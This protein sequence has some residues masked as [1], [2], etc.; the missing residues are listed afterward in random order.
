M[1]SRSRNCACC[2]SYGVRAHA[3]AT[4]TLRDAGHATWDEAESGVA[5]ATRLLSWMLEP[6]GPTRDA[7]DAAERLLDQHGSLSGVLAALRFGRD[8]VADVS[9][10]AR[11]NLTRFAESLQ[12][13]LHEEI[14]ETVKLGSVAKIVEYVR[15]ELRH[16]RV[17]MLRILFLDKKNGLIAD[18]LVA[19]GTIDHCPLYPREIVRQVIDLGAASLVLVHNHPSGDPAPSVADVETTR[20]LKLAL[21]TVDCNLLDHIVVGRNSA[22]SM[23]R[24]G[25]I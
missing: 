2:E 3:D 9:E 24:L 10:A 18:R 19:Q 6:S 25:M 15:Y 16:E 20:R 8:T 7:E 22:T 11:R 1:Q 5:T 13:V 17:E 12:H 23:R 21:A 14:E 4:F